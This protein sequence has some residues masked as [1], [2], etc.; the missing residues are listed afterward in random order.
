[1]KSKNLKNLLNKMQEKESTSENA[2][3]ENLSDAVSEKVKGGASA[4]LGINSS[5]C[6]ESSCNGSGCGK[7]PVPKD[8]VPIGPIILA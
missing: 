4:A 3:F 1:M 2:A 6:N 7:T 8:P 5:S